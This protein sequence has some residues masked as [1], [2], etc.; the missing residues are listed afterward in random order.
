MRAACDLVLEAP[1]SR[2]AGAL[3]RAARR[4]PAATR[5]TLLEALDRLTARVDDGP[6]PSADTA[7]ELE[8]LLGDPAAAL[9][10]EETARA[11]RA[12]G[13]LAPSLAPGT[14][15][16][17]LVAALA[18]HRELAVRVAA[19][20][21][22]AMAAPS[23]GAAAS[24]AASAAP[25]IDLDALVDE[26]LA[27]EDPAARQIALA[28]LRSAL[29]AEPP[30]SVHFARRAARV[31]LLLATAA[32]RADA[33]EALADVAWCHGDAAADAGAPLLARA[34]D[35][36]PRVRAAVLRFVGAAGLAS[37]AAL[38]AERLGARDPLEA[39]AAAAALRKLGPSAV[40]A[41]VGTLMDGGLRA[42]DAAAE[43]LTDLPGN[44]AAL[45]AAVERQV[46][47]ARASLG[48]RRALARGFV[49]PVHPLALQR[50]AERAA[51]SLHGALLVLAVLTKEERVGDLAR[52]LVRTQGGRARAVLLEALDALLPPA[53]ARR[54]LPLLEDVTTAPPVN[55]RSDALGRPLLAQGEAEAAARE[56]GDLLLREL[57]LAGAADLENAPAA[58]NPVQERVMPT[59][60]ETIFHLRGL[61]L[62]SRLTTRQLG[63]VAGAFRAER[64]AAR[65]VLIREGEFGDCM[66]LVVSGE[67]EVSR[68]GHVVAREG[69][70]D[71]IGELALF[72]G[73]TRS[74]TITTSTPVELLRLERA[75]L[76]ALLEEEPGIAIGIC[77]TLSR[78]MRELIRET[79]TRR[80]NGGEGL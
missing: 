46:E 22:L 60:L 20:A 51:E 61:D 69:P 16:G 79:E 14:A 3:A 4:A 25:G 15:A 74:A 27:S 34:H 80:R 57:L 77:Q 23:D 37:H 48:V 13:R 24:S 53:D 33:A 31:G 78:K 45:R 75:D 28:E 54:V 65:A 71:I 67:V 8:A 35:A 58:A 39:A 36:D 12:L 5:P 32:T 52:L 76:F 21:R 43:I 72:D 1:A 55:A 17:G 18:Q 47:A 10:T 40:A 38:A 73:E 19:Q 6:R 70:G 11:V 59:R 63:E 64:H 29:L 49:H 30:G 41:V 2:A 44:A 56:S 62:F 42:R 50:L 9:T 26:G 66:Y 68:E 7:H